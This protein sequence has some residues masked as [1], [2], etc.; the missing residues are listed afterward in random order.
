MTTPRASGDERFFTPRSTARTGDYV[1]SED[2]REEK[3]Y[4]PGTTPRGTKK[5]SK[6]LSRTVLVS[7]SRSSHA[8][9]QDDCTRLDRV[10]RTQTLQPLEV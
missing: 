5:E 10:R 7:R 4:N 3:F 9:T 2:E 6:S 8:H 1:S